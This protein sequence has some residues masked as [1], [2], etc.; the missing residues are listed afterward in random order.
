MNYLWIAVIGM[1]VN[2]MVFLFTDY[3]L[4][5]FFGIMVCIFIFA[6]VTSKSQKL[7][8]GKAI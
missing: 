6:F 4:W 3:S 7:K 5:Y 8:L 1:F 2:F